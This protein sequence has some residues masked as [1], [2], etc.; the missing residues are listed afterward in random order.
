LARICI[1]T[2]SIELFIEGQA[3]SR[4]YD[5][6]PH[7]SP[8]P[9]PV[10]KLGRR[11]TG[12]LRKKD[13]L[14]KGTGGRGAKSHDRK[15]SWSPINHSI[16]SASTIPHPWPLPL[17]Y[18]PPAPPVS[19]IHVQMYCTYCILFVTLMNTQINN[20]PTTCALNTLFPRTHPSLF[21][22]EPH[23]FFSLHSPRLFISPTIIVLT[24][25]TADPYLCPS[26]LSFSPFP[27]SYPH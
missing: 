26:N 8:P 10:N 18:P 19:H 1:Q 13:N 22:I 21:Y 15:I 4:S 24:N 11:N 27:L 7:Q 25:F 5:L 12:R 14:L 2:E 20:C 3:F 6:V 23:T 16:F 9:S 17:S